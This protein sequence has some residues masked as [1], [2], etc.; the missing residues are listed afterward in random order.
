MYRRVTFVAARAQVHDVP[1]PHELEKLGQ[2]PVGTV[3]LEPTPTPRR[4]DVQPRQ[5]IHGA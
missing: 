2:A 4:G 5:R 3:Q 1:E